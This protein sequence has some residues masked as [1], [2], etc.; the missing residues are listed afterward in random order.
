MLDRSASRYADVYGAWR[1]D[2][3]AFWGAAARD[4]QWTTL[5]ETIFDPKAGVY[6]RWFTDGVCNACANAVDRHVADGRGAQAAL[7]FD[8]PVT[9][10]KRTLTYDDLLTEFAPLAPCC[11]G[12]VSQGR[13]RRHLHAHGAGGGGGHAGLC[14]HRCGAF[15]GVWRVSRPRNWLPASMMPRRSD[16]RCFPAAS[17]RAGWCPTSPCWIRPSRCRWRSR[18]PASSSSARNLPARC[19]RAATTTGRRCATRL[20]P[21][22][23]ARTACPWRRRTRFTSSTP[24]ERRDFPRASCAIQAAIS[25]RCAGAWKTSMASSQ[26]TFSGAPPTSAGWWAIPTSC[27]GRSSSAPPPSSMRA[28]RWARPIPVPSGG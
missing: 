11:R 20:S 17:S 14:A 15:R 26:E 8:S 27:M 5:P 16:P 2:P 23:K 3:A 9:S 22:G 12:W 19:W 6:G 4:I 10:T 25:S 28:S 18:T 21:L 1:Q 24:P 13:S 7:I